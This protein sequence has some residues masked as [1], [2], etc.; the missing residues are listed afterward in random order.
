MDYAKPQNHFTDLVIMT[1]GNPGT[2]DGAIGRAYGPVY[3]RRK[4][5]RSGPA[6]GRCWCALKDHKD[7]PGTTTT[8]PGGTTERGDILFWPEPDRMDGVSA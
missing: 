4:N 5:F 3:T 8:R 1:R 2:G 7:H 6:V